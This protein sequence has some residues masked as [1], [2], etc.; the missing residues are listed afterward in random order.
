MWTPRFRA[1]VARLACVLFIAACA[2]PPDA[3][4]KD[5]ST[6]A[7]TM[8]DVVI[9]TFPIESTV[10]SGQALRVRTVVDNR[11][12]HAVEVPL[13]TEPSPFVYF[14]RSQAA[15]GPSYG[16]SQKLTDQRR[17]PDRAGSPPLETEPLAGGTKFEYGED[18]A[19]FWNAGF[20]PGAYW[21]TVRY[22]AGGIESPKSAVTILPL[23]VEG[24]SSVVS[25]DHLSSVAVHRREDGQVLLLQR[26][27]E[28]RDPREGDFRVVHTWPAG[29]SPAAAT[30]IDV[31][32]AGNGRWIAWLMEGKL[33]AI[34]VWGDRVLRTT[35]PTDAPGTLLSPG[36]QT[37]VGT[38]LFGTVSAQGRL[39]TVVASSAGLKKG[40]SA[41]LG[42]AVARARWNAQADGTVTVAWEEAASGRV[43]R[44]EFG[45]DGRPHA[46]APFA[47]TP[48][49]PLAWGMPAAGAATIWVLMLDGATPVV[50]RFPPRGDRVL[51]RLPELRG[52]T[53]WDLLPLADAGDAMAAIAGDKVHAMRLSDTAWN[54]VA[55]APRA[56]GLH[57]MALNRRTLWAEWFESGYG[58]RRARVP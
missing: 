30:S 16:L 28:Q 35:G 49:K 21:L 48:G 46:A 1:R 29:S 56:S 25:V 53:G 47:A 10:L 33:T 14:L 54:A 38:A 51:T 17:S 27:S 55:D 58:I 6:G 52:A 9:A 26:E 39:D 8:T 36:F 11:G 45:A 41:E 43:M 44:Q 2:W 42:S 20:E 24:L 18:I 34:N 4:P 5:P 19:E 32:P 37:G 22:D 13:R 3:L 23:Q 15:G 31:A 12:S 7:K 57:L 40:W 50:A